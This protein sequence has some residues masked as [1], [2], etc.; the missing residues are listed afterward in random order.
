[1]ARIL[2]LSDTHFAPS[3][4]PLRKAGIDPRERLTTVLDAVTDKGPF[5]AVVLTG[6]ICDDGSEEAARDVLAAV[7]GV[8][9]IVL[10]VSGNHDD[11]ATIAEVF[12]PPNAE[13]GEWMV[14]GAVTNVAQ[15][16]QGDAR[17]LVGALAH[18]EEV[19]PDRPAVLLHHHPVHSRSTHEWF[20]L[21]HRDDVLD[22]LEQRTAPLLMLSGHTH[23]P[24]E[25]HESPLHFVGAPSTYYAIAHDGDAWTKVDGHTG[26]TIIDL[27][28]GGTVAVEFVTA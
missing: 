14:I 2:Q 23:E 21:E 22:A 16:V 4:E 17:P 6:D 10:G 19:A 5:D 18:L 15:Q 9:P 13:L 28:D 26:A 25:R 24:F 8:A 12:G 27:F 20:T 3:D 11:S 1:M 7:Q